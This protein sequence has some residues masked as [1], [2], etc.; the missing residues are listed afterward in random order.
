MRRDDLA[1]RAGVDR[2]VG[3]AAN[4][5]VHR[6]MVHACAAAD[7]LQGFA[8]LFVG[9][10]LRA[11]VVQ[12]HQ[13][14]LARAVFFAGLAR[15]R[16]HIE[17]GGDGLA[18]GRA[19]QDGIQRN[20]VAEF[21]HHFF[22]AGDGDVHV[23]HGGAHAAIAFVF[24]Q[25]QRAGFRHGKV[26]PG[27][28]DIGLQIHAAQGIAAQ[29]DQL[30]H[31]FGVRRG[32][33][34]VVKQRGDLRLGF[35]NR[36]HDDVAGLFARQLD[37]VLAHIAFHRLHAVRFQ[38]VVQ[39]GFFTDHRLALDR[40][41][42]LP[43]GDQAMDDGVGFFRGFRPMHFYAI[44]GE[45]GFQ[46]FQQLRQLGQAALAHGFAQAA[47]RFQLVVVGKLRRALGHQEVHRPAKALA[48][49][50]VVHRIVAIGLE[51]ARRVHG[52]RMRAHWAASSSARS[53]SSGTMASTISS[54]GPCAP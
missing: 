28:P 49:V 54:R 42:A 29:L 6:A 25:A 33:D 27:N 3:V 40:Q 45:L 22:N 5:A 51:A 21:F 34:I 50:R 39:L 41:L 14:H 1:N 23:R 4:A 12:Q 7:A 16:D 46:F 36:R 15:A 31:V 32:R 47:Q 13:M 38:V 20:H 8:Q 53:M 18:G 35:V 48:Q 2:A 52:N 30:V 9:V 44:G 10:G 26:H 19:R 37:D 43:G 11:A 17:I 24:H